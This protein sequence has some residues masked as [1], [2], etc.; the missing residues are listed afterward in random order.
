MKVSIARSELLDACLSS[1]RGCPLAR[2]SRSFRAS[3]SPPL[4]ERSSSSRRIW[5]YR[6]GNTAPALIEQEGQIVL[7]GKL[8][9]DIVRNLPEAAVTIETE[10][11][12][13]HVR[14]QHSSFTVRT[15]NPADFPKFPEVAVNKSDQ[16]PDPHPGVDGEAGLPGGQPRRD[17]GHS[18]R[19][20]SRDRGTRRSHGGHGH[21]PSGRPRGGSREGRRR[22]RRGGHPGQGPRRGDPTRRRRR[23]G[24]ARSQ[25]EPGR[26]RVR[27]HRLRDPAGSKGP[28]RT[29]SS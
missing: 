3:C 1:A 19:N 9:S 13:A 5:R 6:S 23:R 8:L 17:P 14:C 18:H 21:L 4:T 15:L 12:T 7:P 10:G 20:P 24:G 22:G 29:T 28:S 27:E 16:A 2:H 11:E 25:R 26:L